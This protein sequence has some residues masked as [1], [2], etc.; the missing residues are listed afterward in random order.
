MSK[1]P[2]E[3]YH[4][5]KV[6]QGLTG[7]DASQAN[8]I[9]DKLK[10]R[11]SERKPFYGAIFHGLNTR[12]H[13]TDQGLAWISP[14]DINFTFKNIDDAKAVFGDDSSFK[15]LAKQG[16]I[17][18]GKMLNLVVH[19]LLHLIMGHFNTPRGYIHEICNIAMDAELHKVMQLDGLRKEEMPRGVIWPDCA[20]D[21]VEV[22]GLGV[23]KVPDLKNKTWDQI[24]YDILDFFEKEGKKSGGNVQS[25][26]Q[27]LLDSGYSPDVP[28]GNECPD[29]PISQAE[30]QANIDG[31]DQLIKAAFERTKNAGKMPAGLDR[32][33]TEFGQEK[34]HWTEKF[35][36]ILR[37][38]PFVERIE[39]VNN[40]KYGHI[41]GIPV[42]PRFRGERM[43]NMW[44]V[45]DTS[46]SIMPE[47]IQEGVNEIHAIRRA[48]NAELFVTSCDT[49]VYDI[50]KFDIYDYPEADDLPIQ[51]GGGTDFRPIFTK[52]SEY[53]DEGKS[54][55]PSVLVLVTD[56]FGAFPEEEPGYPVICLIPSTQKRYWGDGDHFRVPEWAEVV[57]ME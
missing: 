49:R 30:M 34:V 25:M 3:V 5:D 47:D 57:V 13:A 29:D 42:I 11:L 35:S 2:N 40:S 39:N 32:F 28:N 50:V 17:G 22:T 31:L 9:I 53:V 37:T 51:G 52:V 45:F 19:E 54:E 15:K 43:D 27:K 20:N 36:N 21:T 56:T 41:T 7:D 12:V 6:V 48:S 33:V 26:V 1:D 24:Y 46:G 14:Y 44:L 8:H 38:K 55:L 23:C 16:S 10:Y 18:T 4:P